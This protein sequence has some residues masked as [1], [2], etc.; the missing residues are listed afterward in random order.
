MLCDLRLPS[1]TGLD[2]LPWPRVDFE[3]FG[4]VETRP[5]PR[6]RR[7]AGA[8]LARNWVMIPHVTQ[9]DEADITD[10]EAHR[11]HLNQEQ[12]EGGVKVTLLAFLMK[13]CVAALRQFPDFNAAFG[14]MSRVALYAEKQDHHPEW[15]NVY[16]RVQIILATHD[17]GDGDG[18]EDFA[19]N[20]PDGPW[21]PDESQEP[22]WSAR[23]TLFDGNWLNWKSNP[24]TVTRTRLQV[25]RPA[26]MAT[27]APSSSTLRKAAGSRRV[28]RAS[29]SQR[30]ITGAAIPVLERVA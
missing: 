8:N 26:P 15:S 21:G 18:G 10:L 27:T 11:V 2:L 14:F 20:G 16:N 4:P 5:L 29:A 7:I 13:A 23:V 9:V 17:A 25:S 28:Q 30:R 1:G 19:A 12:G 3:R 22:A 6:I 24:P